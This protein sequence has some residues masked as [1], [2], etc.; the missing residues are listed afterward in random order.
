VPSFVL[1]AG[2]APVASYT[3]LAKDYEFTGSALP[4]DWSAGVFSYGY[5]ATLYQPSQVSMTGSSAALTAINTASGGYPYQSGWIS[6]AGSYTLTHGVIDFRAKMPSGQG[7]WSGLW[8]VNAAGSSPQGEIDIQE[9]LLG[10]THTVNGSLHGWAPQPIWKETQA[11]Q[12][13]ADASQGFHD[14]QVIWQPGMLTWAVDGTAYAQYTQAQ[15][16]ASNYPWP[17]DTATGTYLVADL[18]VASPNEWGGAPN[19]QTTFPATMQIQS[20]EVWQ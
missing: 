18:A 15:A 1:P 7:L 9:M 11:T 16:I 3:T 13:A 2:F 14:Y 5:Q 17:F 10:D 8:A 19:A 12:I 20:V 6:T 4:T